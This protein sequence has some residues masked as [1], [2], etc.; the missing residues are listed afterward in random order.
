[1]IRPYL[2]GHCISLL[3]AGATDAGAGGEEVT[4]ECILWA[5]IFLVATG[6]RMLLSAPVISVLK[7]ER[8]TSMEALRVGNSREASNGTMMLNDQHL[9]IY[10]TLKTPGNDP[11]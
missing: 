10:L 6:D 7:W 2:D 4:V 9:V 8:G 5:D 1:M 3:L 11:C